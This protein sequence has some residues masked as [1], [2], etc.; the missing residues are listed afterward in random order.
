M[1]PLTRYDVEGWDLGPLRD[2]VLATIDAHMDRILRAEHAA[3]HHATETE[4]LKARVL[5]LEAQGLEHWNAFCRSEGERVAAEA[6]VLELERERDAYKL[7]AREGERAAQVDRK[8]WEDEEKAHAEALKLAAEE[9]GRLRAEVARLISACHHARACVV[10]AR[11]C[12]GCLEVDAALS[13]SG[14]D[15]W[16]ESVKAEARKEG[17]SVLRDLMPDVEAWFGVAGAGYPTSPLLAART[18][19]RLSEPE[20]VPENCHREPC[21]L[22][23]N[24]LAAK[25]R[26]T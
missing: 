17:E 21:P 1:T 13:S 16:L 26:T 22:C 2:Q 18:F 9:N 20:H 23:E 3:N 10:F 25:A 6:R 7:A 15:E 5:E 11:V 12:H 14:T 24:A 8:A 19:L 4:K